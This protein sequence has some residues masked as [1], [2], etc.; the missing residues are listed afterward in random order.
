MEGALEMLFLL[1]RIGSC[2]AKCFADGRC[3][4][5]RR[6]PSRIIPWH[7]RPD[8]MAQDIAPGL[9]DANYKL[10][11]SPATAQKEPPPETPNSIKTRALVILSFW[12]V[13][14]LLG[15]PVWIWT[16]S[17]H[18]ASLPLQNMLDW[19]DGKVLV[20]CSLVHISR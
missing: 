5:T 18:R 2:S 8:S 14:I 6:T 4:R 13:V 12:A 10:A 11:S 9:D 19:A 1:P 3:C 20:P 16:T 15:L 17:I 7:H